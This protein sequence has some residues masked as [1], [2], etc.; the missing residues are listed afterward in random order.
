[1]RRNVSRI[2]AKRRLRESRYAIREWV[3]K[4]PG[5]PAF[6]LGN[7]PSLKDHN[8][9]LLKDYF[10]IGINRIFLAPSGA[11]GF[12]PTVLLWQDVS[13]FFTEYYRLANLQ[14]LKVARDIADPKRLFF[15][16]HLK[17]G[18]FKFNPQKSCHI[19]FGGGSSGPLA[20]QLAWAL[21]CEPLVLIG[22]DCQLG[23][24]GVTD[25][26]GHNSYWSD[27]TLLN[28]RH[29]L[30]FLKKECPAEIISCGDAADL[31]PRQE[32]TDVLKTIDPIH[33]RGRN[34]YVQQ[35]SGT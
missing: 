19:L 30:E 15:N 22:M 6:I 13:L 25:F 29:G 2:S 24:N 26:Y 21:G 18:P 17:P 35:L 11:T 14:C 34:S 3:G 23:S 16:F 12:D 4:L 8:L 1:M 31:W 7:A 33:A 10:T 9:D 20:C 5:V 28:C 27:R 32:L